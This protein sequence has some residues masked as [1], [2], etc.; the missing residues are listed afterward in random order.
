MAPPGRM[1][2]LMTKPGIRTIQI[3]GSHTGGEPARIVIADGPELGAG[4]IAPDHFVPFRTR[5]LFGGQTAI[6]D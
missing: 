4:T 3:I 5:M 1:T 2:P 6:F